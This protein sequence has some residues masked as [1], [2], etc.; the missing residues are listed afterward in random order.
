MFGDKTLTDSVLIDHKE[1]EVGFR[2]D[3]ILLFSTHFQQKLLQQTANQSKTVCK[4]RH[5][6]HKNQL[7]CYRTSRIRALIEHVVL[8]CVS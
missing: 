6:V 4:L 1:T 3:S 8:I 7:F 5:S 2:K